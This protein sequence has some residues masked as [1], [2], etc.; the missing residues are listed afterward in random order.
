MIPLGTTAPDFVLPDVVSGELLSLTELRSDKATVV[1]FICNHCPFVKHIQHGLVVLAKEYQPQGISFAAVNSN[2]VEN[3]PED[4]PPRMKETAK[5]LHY[6]FPYLYDQSQEVAR[7]Y[8]AACTP[9]F[10]C[11]RSRAALCLSRTV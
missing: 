1:M 4:S 9:D 7:A 5:A 8:R 10:L 6:P 11:L 2:D 3:Y